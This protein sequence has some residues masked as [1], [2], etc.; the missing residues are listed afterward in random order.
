M[1]MAMALLAS[2]LMK[3]DGRARLTNDILNALAVDIVGANTSYDAT[4]D[5]SDDP[6]PSR[7]QWASLRRHTLKTNQ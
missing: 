5:K 3:A 1:L 7:R 4:L 6:R 2:T